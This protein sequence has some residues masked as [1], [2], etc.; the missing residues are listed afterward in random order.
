MSRDPEFSRKF[1]IRRSSRLMFGTD[2]LRPE[3]EIPQFDIFASMPLPKEV[4]EKVFR[5]NAIELLKL[6]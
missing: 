4:Q 1:V 5:Q 2:Y 3:Q 6:G